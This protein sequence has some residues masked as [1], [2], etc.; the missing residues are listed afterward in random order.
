M[1]NVKQSVELSS[2]SDLKGIMELRSS[3]IKLPLVCDL[4]SLISNTKSAEFVWTGV[5]EVKFTGGSLIKVTFYSRVCG[6]GMLVLN[7]L[8]DWK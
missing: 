5:G 8:Q 3:P 4:L 6:K 1:N 7:F 2:E